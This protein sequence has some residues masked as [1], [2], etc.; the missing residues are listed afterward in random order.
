[1]FPELF[2]L[3][4]H[5]VGGSLRAVECLMDAHAAQPLAP[6]IAM[7]WGGG[8]HHADADQAK[9]FCFCGDAVCACLRL[10]ASPAYPRVLYLD[11]DLH[12]GDGVE[13][14]FSG[15]RSVF[16]LSFH[17]LARGF[18]PGTGFMDTMGQGNAKHR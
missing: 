1:M 7:H 9:G 12:H 17:H 14:A 5:T 15:S 4:E 16:T 11:L 13:K 18:F 3:V 10:Q 8:R 2:S 6:V